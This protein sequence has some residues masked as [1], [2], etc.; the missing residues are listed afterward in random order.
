MLYLFDSPNSGW[1]FLGDRLEEARG[2]SLLLS[3]PPSSSSIVPFIPRLGDFNPELPPRNALYV[4]FLV[5]R[6]IL[7]IDGPG[8]LRWLFVL[9]P[10]MRLPLCW[11]CCELDTMTAN[12]MMRLAVIGCRLVV[13]SVSEK[14]ILQIGTPRTIMFEAWSEIPCMTWPTIR[15]SGMPNSLVDSWSGNYLQWREIVE[16]E[17]EQLSEL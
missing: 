14:N 13:P 4:L 10:F 9:D 15:Y 1:G 11:D 8:V 6:N 2:V 17:A 16:T 5:L 7:Y 12:S 3:Y